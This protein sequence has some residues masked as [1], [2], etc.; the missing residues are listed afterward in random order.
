[1]DDKLEIKNWLISGKFRILVLKNL[2]QG[3]KTPSQLANN[4][5]IN[6]A[7]ISRILRVLKEK[8]LVDWTKQ[9]A[10]TK[11]CYLTQEGKEAITLNDF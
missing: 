8:K 10:K 11:L 3:P 5:D 1:V 2:E 7:S 4:L 6:R 9:S